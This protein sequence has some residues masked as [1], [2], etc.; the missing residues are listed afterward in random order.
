MAAIERG[1]RAGTDVKLS[2]GPEVG[3][4]LAFLVRVTRAERVLELGTGL[5]YSAIWM[6]EGLRTTGG[7]LTTVEL[8]QD[9]FS[10][11]VRNIEAAGMSGPVHRYNEL[12]FADP[13]LFSTILPVGDGV[14]LSVKVRSEVV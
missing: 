9:A 10:R 11:A 3:R 8:D 1:R 13:R 6:A 14:A 4:L 5:G 7:K 12:V 2:V